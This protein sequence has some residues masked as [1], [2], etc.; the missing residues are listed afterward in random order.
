MT[1]PPPSLAP[2]QTAL[3][4]AM[5]VKKAKAAAKAHKEQLARAKHTNPK[6]ADDDDDN[7]T[8]AGGG[9]G[10]VFTSM[11][12]FVCF[13]PHCTAIHTASVLC[14]GFWF[15]SFSDHKGDRQVKIRSFR[16]HPI[17]NFN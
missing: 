17:K 11:A 8:E 7:D 10:L 12:E 2:R 3:V 13:S 6:N 14:R 15:V 4:R 1:F 16:F 9:E 5:K